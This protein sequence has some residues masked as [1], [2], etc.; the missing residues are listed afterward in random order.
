MTKIIISVLFTIFLGCCGCQTQDWNAH[1]Y[2]LNAQMHYDIAM[3]IISSISLHANEVILDIGC[4]DGRT[5]SKLAQMVPKGKV[6]GIDS[7][8]N[9]I[10]YAQKNYS[11][12]SNLTFK[13]MAAEEIQFDREFDRIVSFFALHYVFDHELVLEN[14]KRSLKPQGTFISLMA[15]RQPDGASGD[16]LSD[17]FAGQEKWNTKT[18]SEYQTLLTD[19]GFKPLTV[20]EHISSFVFP[21]RQELFHWLWGCAA[22]VAD[23]EHEKALEIA[24]AIIDKIAQGKEENIEMNGPSLYARAEIA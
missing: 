22:H 11:H 3:N 2:S 20:C 23:Y 21:T 9:M 12:I 17:F 7:S 8:Q 5:T 19:H 24:N 14:I 1:Q 18:V 16:A 10:E 15:L 4:G 6:I 13:K